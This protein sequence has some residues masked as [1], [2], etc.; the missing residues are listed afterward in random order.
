MDLKKLIKVYESL[1]SCIKLISFRVRPCKDCFVGSHASIKNGSRVTIGCGTRIEP[2]ALLIPVQ[3]DAQLQIGSQVIV[4]MFSRIACNN[5]VR[6]DDNTIMG[7]NVFISDFNHEYIDPD[8]PIRGQGETL[9]GRVHICSDSWLGTGV[10]VC[11]NVKIGKHCVI[12]ANSVVTSD[13]PEYSVAVGAPA[14]V[15]KKYNPLTSKWERVSD[16]VHLE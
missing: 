16:D 8:V 4:G 2:Y 10:V 9:G 13:I 15:I 14:R 11:G 12:G 7:P 5:S 3:N 1:F 6:I